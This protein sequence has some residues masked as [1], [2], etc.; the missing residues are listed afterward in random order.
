MAISV[1]KAVEA[2][3]EY[4]KNF[5]SILPS[6]TGLRLEETELSDDPFLWIVTVS[7][8]AQPF[9]DTARVYK[10]FRIDANSGEVISMK[11]THPF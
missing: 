4:L 11:N 6:Q 3:T 8:Q 1:K 10:Q 7:F 2:A 9:D 5:S